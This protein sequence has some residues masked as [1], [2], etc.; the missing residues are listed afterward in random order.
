MV[1]RLVTRKTTV[2]SQAALGL[3]LALA[4]SSSMAQ[5]PPPDHSAT[6]A[7]LFVE[8]LP[9]GTVSVRVSR[10]SMTDSIAN[11]DVVGS[12]TTKDGQAKSATVKTGEDGRAVFAGVPA[13]STF[14]A[15]ATVEGENLATQQFTVP[16]QG[17]TRLLVIVGAQAEEAMTEMTGGAAT[18]KPAQPKPLGVRSGK[19]EARDG[20]KDGT[21]DV[22]V[23][24]EEGK[25]IPGI[26]VDLGRT[27]HG[28][29]GVDFV[30]AVSD[31]SGVA[32]FTDLKSGDG[33]AYAAVIERDGI[34]V[35]T[36]AFT[37]DAKR[38]TVGE[39]RMPGRTHDLSALR[40]SSSSRMMVELREDAIGVLQNL[41]VENTSDKIFDPGPR[42]LY[43]PLPDGF[44]G[45]EK[46][47]GGVELEIKEGS[48]AYLH[49]MLPPAQSPGTI[50]SVR[51]GYLLATHETPTFE[52]VQPM[53]LGL[54]GALV[55]IPSEYAISV[56]APGL[57][58]RP[59]ERD[60][61]GNELH[62]FELAAVPPGQ[63]LHLTVLGLPTRHQ[64]GKW[65]AAVLASLI[66][67]AGF[68]TARRP[69]KALGGKA[70]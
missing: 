9:V 15:K 58:A 39:I 49:A 18:G 61:N 52:I 1:P 10:P 13:G 70:G 2:L 63:A 38:G 53:P 29:G 24:T 34:R 56:S 48:G 7:P 55:L 19:V 4:A 25:P 62:M 32:H 36:P 47:A 12:W 14:G 65:I 44:S 3:A 69:R 45:A 54:E 5:T 30:H 40:I 6:S 57:R 20:L 50:A 51:V 26:G 35:G 67:A 46:L 68:V 33:S 31:A 27:Q 28:G 37:L 42:G 21:V 59:P 17:G 16:D 64:A 8:D 22:T 66:V 43:I 60:D 41:L 23:L 11:V